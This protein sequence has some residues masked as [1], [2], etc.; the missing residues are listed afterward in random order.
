MPELPEVETIRRDLLPQLVGRGFEG[1]ELSDA[2]VVHTP[3]S[4]EF[5]ERIQGQEIKDVRRRG[6]YLII[7]LSGGDTLIIH[8]K[9]SG[10]LH[11]R[12]LPDES[13]MRPRAVFRLDNG[14]EL[15]FY[16]RRKLGMMWVTDDEDK[17]VGKL[18]PEPLDSEFTV[19]VLGAALGRYNV[20]A[21]TLLCD[22][23][24][25]AGIGNMYADEALFAARIHPLT[26]GKDLTV[27]AV[28]RLHTAI[29]E[30]L[31]SAIVNGGASVDTYQRPTGELGFA[32]FFFRVAHRRNES[33]LDCSSPL[34][35]IV[36][37]GRGT[38]FCPTCQVLN[39]AKIVEP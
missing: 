14:G 5:T 32:Q 3:S 19:E 33:C 25:I 7:P 23:H 36:V 2:K 10:F 22:Q 30:I 11:F 37:R 24:V 34:Q 20:A 12:A 35:R 1:V 17:I 18:G 15:H 28:K 13:E 39:Q 6:K 21:K 16:D 31:A 8:L 27:N 4:E 38:Y 9:M 26:K 29:R